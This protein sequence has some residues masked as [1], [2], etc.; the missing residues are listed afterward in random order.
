VTIF[1]AERG[2][3][4][5][6]GY[7]DAGSPLHIHHRQGDASSSIDFYVVG[8]RKAQ[9]ISFSP[10]LPLE[11]RLTEVATVIA[12]IDA[13]PDEKGSA[14]ASSN[15]NPHSFASVWLRSSLL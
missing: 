4:Q 10:I 6:Q 3:Q 1:T 8:T 9:D 13:F 7:Y 2:V 11:L 15:P 12:S 14:I 5:P